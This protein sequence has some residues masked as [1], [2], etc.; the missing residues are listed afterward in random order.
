MLFSAIFVSLKIYFGQYRQ[1]L[2]FFSQNGIII[3][4]V[5]MNAFADELIYCS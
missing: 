2:D 4:F 1:F 5:E 3:K